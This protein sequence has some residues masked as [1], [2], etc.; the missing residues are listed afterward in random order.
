LKIFALEYGATFDDPSSSE[1]APLVDGG[2]EKSVTVECIG[3]YL[4]AVQAQWL[5]DGV[6]LQRKAFSQGLGEVFAVDALLAFTGAEM[7]A[8]VSN[9]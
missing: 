5:G 6:A 8:M 7:I 4:D 1:P 3:E 2:S 9:A